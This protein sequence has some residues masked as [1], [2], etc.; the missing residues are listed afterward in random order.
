MA[1]EVSRTS[2]LSADI[3]RDP[4]TQRS[5]EPPFGCD[6][7][8]R[9]TTVAASAVHFRRVDPR[10][11][12]ENN[13]VSAHGNPGAPREGG[14]ETDLAQRRPASS[15]G[16][17]RKGLGPQTVGSDRRAIHAGHHSALASGTRRPEMGP[18]RQAS[19]GGPASNAAGSRR[20]NPAIGP[21]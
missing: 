19:C 20:S 21:D 5:A 11:S 4:A 7:D 14:Q 17:Q 2:P 12:T 15:F 16:G 18:Q 6:N 3:S 10:R 13:R 1:L 8:F 9:S